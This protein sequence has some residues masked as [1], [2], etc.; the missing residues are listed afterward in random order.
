MANRAQ[1]KMH[2]VLVNAVVEKNGKILICQRSP[3]EIHE[4]GKWTIPGGKVEKTP[5]DIWNMVE[6][7]LA[8]EVLEETDVKIQNKVHLI[9]NNTF[10][11][12]TGQHVIALVF[13]CRYKAGKAKPLEDTIKVKWVFPKEAD[14]YQFAPNVKSYILKGFEYLKTE[15]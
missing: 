7:T 8:R 4:P 9:T 3:D 6:K 2:L 12:S 1:D 15:K 13:L 11:R 14:S 10:I 5:G